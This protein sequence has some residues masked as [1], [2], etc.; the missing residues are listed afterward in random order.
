M[1]SSTRE[2]VDPCLAVR[3][4]DGWLA[5]PSLVDRLRALQ[6]TI[7][8]ALDTGYPWM[9]L[10]DARRLVADARALGLLGDPPASKPEFPPV[11]AGDF[12]RPLPHVGW[13]DGCGHLDHPGKFCAI[14]ECTC[15]HPHDPPPR[16]ARRPWAKGGDNG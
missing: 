8:A 10:D 15:E 13:C 14:A 3:T 16:M 12:D 5:V 2:A 11:Q 7:D 6:G 9:A 4:L 1:A